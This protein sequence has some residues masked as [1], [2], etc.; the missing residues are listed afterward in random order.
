VGDKAGTAQEKSLQALFRYFA[1]KTPIY[2]YGKNNTAEGPFYADYNKSLDDEL[3]ERF[4]AEGIRKEPVRNE[5]N[6]MQ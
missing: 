4:G 2:V 6:M 5:E 1:G 3:T